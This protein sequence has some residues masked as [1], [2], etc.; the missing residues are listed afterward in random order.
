ADVVPLDHIARGAAVRED[1][2]AVII[3][4]DDVASRDCGAADGV[5]A[6]P[7]A[8]RDAAGGGADARA[9]AP[10]AGVGTRLDFPRPEC[11]IVNGRLINQTAPLTVLAGGGAEITDQERVVQRV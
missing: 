11:A 8:N 6:R 2:P 5:V 1:H 3:A 10:A 7:A 9:L 4:A